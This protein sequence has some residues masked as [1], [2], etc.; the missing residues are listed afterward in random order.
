MS[1]KHPALSGLFIRFVS[2]LIGISIS[3]ALIVAMQLP[4]LHSPAKATHVMSSVT[5]G[6]TSQP[7]NY[8]WPSV[9]SA[10]ISVPALGL[11]KSNNDVTRPIASL[12]KMMTAYVVLLKL[13]LS[14]PAKSSTDN[15]PC[16]VITAQD[17]STYNVMKSQGESNAYVTEGEKICERD[18]LAGLLVHSANNY[19]A[20]LA[21]MTSGSVENFVNEMNAQTQLIGIVSTHYVDPSGFSSGSVSTA[22]DQVQ[23]ASLL[24]QSPLVR[25]IVT[26]SSV[27]LPVAGKVNSYTPYVGTN[28]VIGV[29]SGRTTEAG[30]CN[31]MAMTFMING[32]PQTAYAVVLGAQGS[33]SLASAGDAT[34]TLERSVISM[35]AQDASYTFSPNFS[36]GRIGWGSNTTTF[37]VS[38]NVQV[39]WSSVAHGLP[40]KF[41]SKHI[42]SRIHKGDV[43]GWLVINGSKKYRIAVVAQ[44]GAVPLTLW[45]RLR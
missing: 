9:G 2:V 40:V 24:M 26:H 38:E 28:D 6:A 34:L 16:V 29:K 25:S 1:V 42:T 31:A 8:A 37:G 33:D 35:I 5:V 3:V 43:V 32:I 27:D 14:Y 21:V 19:A 4:L 39:S 10:S 30:G 20:L 22:Q 18:L 41:V 45:Q 7:A 11:L 13:P 44:K 17:V 36:L 12:T 23:L 15:G